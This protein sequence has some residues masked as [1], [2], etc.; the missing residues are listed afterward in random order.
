LQPPANFLDQQSS[1][2]QEEFPQLA[3]GGEEKTQVPKRGDENREPQRGP[4][5]D[6][7]HQGTCP[8][9]FVICPYYLYSE[10]CL[11]VA[12]ASSDL[13][14]LLSLVLLLLLL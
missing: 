1:Q 2:F 8:V 14:E 13:T 5:L 7:K 4:V 11:Y 9:Y 12:L 10:G 6:P 3:P